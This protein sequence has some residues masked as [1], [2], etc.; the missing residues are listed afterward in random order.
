[1]VTSSFDYH[2]PTSVAEAADLLAQHG[3]GAKLLAG[4]HS[5]IPLMKTRLAEPAVL[6]DLGRIESMSYI[7]ES[8]G[9]LAIGAMTKYV[10]LESSDLVKSKA[11][12]LSEAA[13]MVA[14]PQVR[15]MGTIGGSLAHA[16]PAADLPAV[17]LAL[18]ARV[19]TS[20]TGGHRT[21]EAGDFFVDLLTTA[22][23][24]NEI[25]SEIVIPGPAPRTG[26]AYAKFGN[27]ASHFAIVGVAASI[28][29]SPNGTCE[30]ARLG[31][32]GAGASASRATEAESLLNGQRLMQGNRPDDDAI[33]AAAAQAGAGIEFQEDIHASAEYRAHLST[34]FAERAIR[35]AVTRAR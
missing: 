23:Q 24:P 28:T 18:G 10:E 20:S 3:D 26:T 6:I 22:L 13:G 34:V 27:K 14:D 4:G 7:R 2:A 11:L 32:T 9:G 30:G 25:L 17:V 31:I 19:I 8:D 35:S 33:K 5:L 21:I 15:N 12:A 29:L 1:M 16:D